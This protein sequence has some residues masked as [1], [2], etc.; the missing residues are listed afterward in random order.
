ML[1]APME[2]E[3]AEHCIFTACEQQHQEPE[4]EQSEGTK[5]LVLKHENVIYTKNLVT[6]I[7]EILLQLV[8][9]LLCSHWS[10]KIS[11]LAHLHG[12]THVHWKL[13][14]GKDKLTWGRKAYIYSPGLSKN[15]IIIARHIGWYILINPVHFSI[16]WKA[17]N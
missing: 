15:E 4:Y 5:R 8:R 7:I 17:K 9:T 1:S 10:A 2:P 6:V 13:I 3:K 11:P 12:D 16:I 14:T